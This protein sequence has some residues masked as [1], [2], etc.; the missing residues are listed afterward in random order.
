VTTLLYLVAAA[1]QQRLA[2]ATARKLSRRTAMPAAMQV[3]LTK[4]LG[5]M[6]ANDFK[7]LAANIH[8]S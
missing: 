2:V 3:A 8:F 7:Y 1:S 6:P 4:Q 5:A